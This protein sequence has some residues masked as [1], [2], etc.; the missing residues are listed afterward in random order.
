MNIF[1]Y[2]IHVT[3]SHLSGAS[4][5]CFFKVMLSVQSEN[6]LPKYVIKTWILGKF[7]ASY[8]D[9]TAYQL[10]MTSVKVVV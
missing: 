8:K 2:I 6:K 4:M 10:S 3:T 5:F 1:I 7:L 9:C